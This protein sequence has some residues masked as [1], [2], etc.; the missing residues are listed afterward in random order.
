MRQISTSG[1]AVSGLVTHSIVHKNSSK[2]QF[3]DWCCSTWQK[4]ISMGSFRETRQA[5]LKNWRPVQ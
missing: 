3:L 5:M 4:R 2:L 1:H